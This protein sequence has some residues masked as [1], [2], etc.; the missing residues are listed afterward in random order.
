MLFRSYLVSSVRFPILIG[1]GIH[2]P[3]DI[4]VGL[5]LGAKGFLL[6]TDVVKAQ[7]PEE[8]LRELAEV[9]EYHPLKSPS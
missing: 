1:A 7:N 3:E 2:S 8:Q 4:R 6:A 9:F 5:E